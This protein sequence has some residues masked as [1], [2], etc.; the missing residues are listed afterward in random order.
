MN[1]STLFLSQLIGPV[2][3][4]VGLSFILRRNEMMTLIKQLVKNNVI[5]WVYGMAELT[6]GIAIVMYHN[7]WNSVAAFIISLLG[8]GMILEGSFGVLVNKT[9][10]K[11]WMGEVNVGVFNPSGVVMVLAGICLIWNGYLA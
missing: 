10:L 1:E 4:I 5:L 6:A 8:W 3:A 11:R 9:H 7:E 2:L